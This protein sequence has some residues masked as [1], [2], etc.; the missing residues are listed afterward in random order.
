MARHDGDIDT[1]GVYATLLT[2]AEVSEDVVY[3]ITKAVFESVESSTEF[4][5]E[6]QA[7]LSGQFSKGLTAPMHPGALR[8]Y[9]EAG[10]DIPSES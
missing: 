10:I 3:A 7:L 2:S 4:R 8:Y 9:R 6:F 1:I 5:T